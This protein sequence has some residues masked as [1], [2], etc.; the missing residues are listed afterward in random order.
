VND[1]ADPSQRVFVSYIDKSREYYLAQD[2]GNPYRWAYHQDSPFAPLTKPLAECRVGLVT[3]A[4]LVP[5]GS[6]LD[7]LAPPE[8]AVFAA[9]LEPMPGWLYT[10]HRSWDKESTHTDDLDSFFPVHRLQ[11]RAGEGRIR[12][13]APRFYGIPTEYSQRRTNEADAPEL[14]R[15]CRK[16]GVDVAI[17]VPL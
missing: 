8:K 9:P 11:E 14:L 3:T 6:K 2:Y 7:P 13:V 4:S 15:L 10:M 12:D 5:H 1:Q 17:L 16:D